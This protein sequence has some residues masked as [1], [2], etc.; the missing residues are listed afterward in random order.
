MHKVLLWAVATWAATGCVGGSSNAGGGGTGLIADSAADGSPT[1]DSGS[2]GDSSGTDAALSPDVPSDTSP[3][4]DSAPTEVASVDV[5]K[6]DVA[7]VDLGAVDSGTAVAGAC[8][9]PADQKIVDSGVVAKSTEKCA[10]AS[11]GDA[12]KASECIKKETGLSDGCV[13]CFA[14]LLSCTFAKCIADCMGG[15][16][17][18]CDACLAKNCNASFTTCSGLTP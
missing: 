13:T 6:V 15:Q 11:F 18:K 10:L 3:P 16:T 5:A 14:D 12:K 7:K 17:P 2:A 1:A 4:A 8:T 9:N